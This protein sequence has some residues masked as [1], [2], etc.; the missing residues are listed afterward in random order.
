MGIED[1]DA[2]Y[3]KLHTLTTVEFYM[4][5]KILQKNYREDFGLTFGH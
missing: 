1:E 2:V 3:M 5:T 4:N